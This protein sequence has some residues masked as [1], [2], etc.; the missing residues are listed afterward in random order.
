MVVDEDLE[1]RLDRFQEDAR[2]L[3]DVAKQQRHR[4]VGTIPPAEHLS[5][6]G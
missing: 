6:I 1:R 3:V 5:I 4:T 2:I